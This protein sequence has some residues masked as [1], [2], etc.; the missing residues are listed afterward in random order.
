[1]HGLS[2]NGQIVATYAGAVDRQRF[3]CMFNSFDL[4]PSLARYSPGDVLLTHVI[5]TQC[6]LGRTVLDLGVGEARYKSFFCKDVEELADLLLPISAQGKAYAAAV[7]QLLAAKHFI[8]RNPWAWSLVRGLRTGRARLATLLG[9]GSSMP[10][11][12]ADRSA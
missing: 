6:R 10:G 12:T 4:S 9:E 7:Q 3:S 11:T 8:K 5:R 2:L 1:V